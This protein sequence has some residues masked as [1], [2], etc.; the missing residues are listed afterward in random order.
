MI[1]LFRRAILIFQS[2]SSHQ[3]MLHLRVIYNNADNVEDLL[4]KWHMPNTQKS[5]KKSSLKKE[6]NSILKSKEL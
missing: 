1:F 4:M 6:K 3:N 2:M 5:A